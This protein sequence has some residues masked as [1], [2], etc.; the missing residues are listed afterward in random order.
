M[1]NLIDFNQMSLAEWDGLYA[2]TRDIYSSPGDFA[3]ALRSKVLANL[4][5]E[6]STRTS[7]SFQS[8]MQRLGGGV[9]GFSDPGMSSISKG[10]SF[11]DTV[12]ISSTYADV[13][14]IRS[15]QEGAALAAAACCDVPIINA[16]DGGHLH[17]TQTLADLTTIMQLRGSLENLNIALCGDLKYGRTVHSLIKALSRFAGIKYY[18]VS[19]KELG[20]PDYLRKYMDANKMDY[21]QVSLLESVISQVD[22]LY[23]TRIQKERFANPYEYQKQKGVYVLNSKKLQAAKPDMLIMHPLPRVDEITTDVDDDP[24][25]VYFKQAHFG[26]YARMALLITLCKNGGKKV[27]IDPTPGFNCTNSRC[28]TQAEPYLPKGSKLL[29]GEERCIY[30]D[31]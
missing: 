26:M 19:P 31:A 10:E 4:F 2:L 29:N 11:K 23:M 8:A 17:P 3:D 9:F 21:Y 27:H 20:I 25:A 12:I 24:R 5:F 1:H 28:I 14:V 18:L 13:C 22:V 7:F 16:G 30:C 6:P 15:P